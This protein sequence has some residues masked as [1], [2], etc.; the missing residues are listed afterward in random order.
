MTYDPTMTYATITS[1]KDAAKEVLI[2]TFDELGGKA[3]PKD[4]E[5]PRL[6]FPN[7]IELISIT[8]DVS[9]IKVEIKVAGEKGVKGLLE[10]KEI[11]KVT[12]GEVVQE[13]TA[14]Q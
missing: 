5:K 7:G 10:S 4:K 9:G 12:T 2:A 14:K 8:V 3:E 6:F 13:V 11:G 1:A